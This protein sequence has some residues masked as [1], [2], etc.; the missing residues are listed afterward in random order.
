MLLMSVFV[1]ACLQDFVSKKVMARVIFRAVNRAAIFLVLNTFYPFWNKFIKMSVCT[2]S[3]FSF[4]A[5]R[6][7]IQNRSGII[8]TSLS[9]TV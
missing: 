2:S 3:T 9:Q 5:A 7:K 1:E 6:P 8:T 4:K